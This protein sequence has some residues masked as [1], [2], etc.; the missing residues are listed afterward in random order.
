MLAAEDPGRLRAVFDWDMSTLGDPLSDLGALLTYWSEPEDPPAFRAMAMMPTEASG[1]LSRAELVRRYA[2]RSGRDVS[3]IEFYHVLGLFR[4][5]VI[6]AQIYARFHR[7]QT[8][9]ARFAAFGPLI[10]VVAT[11]AEERA[12]AARRS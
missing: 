8:R 11:A 6:A 10:P 12:R 1:F 5:A 2:E 7:G 4:L 3:A 9:D